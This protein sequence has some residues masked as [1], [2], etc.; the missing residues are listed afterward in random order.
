MGIRSEYALCLVAV[1]VA[2]GVGLGLGGLLAA[3]GGTAPVDLPIEV[4]RLTPRAVVA[5]YVGVNVVAV[6]AE[7][8]V[9]VVDSHLSPTIMS[10]VLAACEGELGRD[11]WTW[12]VNTHGH[13]DH[14]RGNQAVVGATRMGHKRCAEYVEGFDAGKRLTLWRR[15]HD[16]V[17]MRSELADT[18]DTSRDRSRLTERIRAQEIILD[19]LHHR[20]VPTPPEETFEDRARIDGGDVTAELIFCGAAHTDH[21]IFVFVP[22]E[23]L[24]L[25]G[26]IFCSGNSLCFGVNALTD[27]DRLLGVVDEILERAPTELVIVPGHGDAMNRDDLVRLRDIVAKK[28]ADVDAGQSAARRIADRQPIEEGLYFDEEEFHVLARWYIG[29]GRL[30]LALAALEA[31]VEH[32]PDSALLH[33]ILGETLF[34]MGDTSGAREHY[35]RS[36]EL[37]PHNRNAEA[38]LELLEGEGAWK[39]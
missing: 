11:D 10:T 5:S 22:E 33:D 4:D 18:T 15:E 34:D 25:T 30:D 38:V 24:L 27:G 31:A 37:A 8:G 7:R 17:R 29:R 28:W 20:F 21:D 39:E 35:E 23:G 13:R 6:T 19:D 12:L 26:D 9:I 1:A 32:L 3:A 16:L 36:L 2:L 14:T